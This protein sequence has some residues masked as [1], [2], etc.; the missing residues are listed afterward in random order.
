MV[1]SIATQGAQNGVLVARRQ[2]LDRIENKGCGGILPLRT[3]IAA[4]ARHAGSPGLQWKCSAQG[5]VESIQSG[6]KVGA[7]PKRGERER[8]GSA[9]NDASASEQCFGE[10]VDG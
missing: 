6:S 3:I 4:V 7:M 10:I 5:T 1:G 2:A 8:G 9:L